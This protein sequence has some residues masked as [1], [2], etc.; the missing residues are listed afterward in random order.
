MRHN[1]SFYL[2]WAYFPSCIFLKMIP[3]GI[4]WAIL[5]LNSL[6]L[7][8][9]LATWQP[10]GN[11]KQMD[12]I[13]IFPNPNC[14]GQ[15]TVLCSTFKLLKGVFT[16]RIR[17]IEPR[18]TSWSFLPNLNC[19]G[20]RTLVRN[21]SKLF[22]CPSTWRLRAIQTSE[23]YHATDFIHGVLVCERPVHRSVFFTIFD[24][25]SFQMTKEFV[26]W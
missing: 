11:T 13:I 14:C 21:T 22:K 20:Q 6:R 12:C 19:C 8:I 25:C 16:W 26:R 23:H 1:I 24:S 10:Q 17:A 7:F 4:F 9:S 18:W 5:V 2:S 15:R 3:R